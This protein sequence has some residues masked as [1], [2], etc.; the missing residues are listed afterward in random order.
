MNEKKNLDNLQY[1]WIPFGDDNLFPQML[2]EL[3]RCAAT[4]RAILN[5]KTTFTIGEGI[6]TSNSKTAKY[7]EDVNADGETINDVLRKVI[8][9]YWT[10][11]N[12]YM[13]VVKGKGYMNL[14]H[15]DATT[16]RVHKNKKHLLLHPDWENARRTPELAKS[17]PIYPNFDKSSKVYYKNV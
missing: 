9:D 6:S 5:T 3:S 15:I 17:L 16:V 13:E 10:H 12:A 1:D 4:H 8:S 7:L 14:Y 11:G 2:S